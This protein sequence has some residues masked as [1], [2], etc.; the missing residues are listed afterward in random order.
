MPTQNTPTNKPPHRTRPAT[1]PWA[2]PPL[3]HLKPP[4]L[5]SSCPMVSIRGGND[6]PSIVDLH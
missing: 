4:P 1:I 3:H 6:R 2:G 5:A